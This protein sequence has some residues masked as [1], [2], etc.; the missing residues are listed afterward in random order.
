M[1]SQTG[2]RA[3]SWLCTYNNPEISFEALYQQRQDKIKYMV[4]QL[5]KGQNN[6]PHFQFF[7]QLASPARL[8]F[9]KNWDKNIHAESAKRP[10]KAI[11]YCQKAE[12]RVDG[13][14][15]FGTYL[16]SGRK[17]LSNTVQLLANKS[18]QELA[19]EL[20][21]IRYNAAVKATAHFKIYQKV[22]TAPRNSQTTKGVWL[23]G[24][25][26]VG[27]SWAA[28]KKWPDLY[29][30]AQNKWWDGYTGQDIALIEDFD[31]QG[32]CLSHYIKIWADCYDFVGEVKGNT[33]PIV[34]KYFVITSNYLPGEIWDTDSILLE[35]I[36]RR[37]TII[38]VDEYNRDEC[39]DNL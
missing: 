29:L 9:F 10:E 20:D 5:E 31:K 16:D 30:K 36:E 38:L 1:E 15:S 37:F 17:C 22:R 21:P 7:V 4:G 23:C 12:S 33:I 28:R 11:D 25:P 3:R 27:K 34:L 26:G 13:P 24:K 35:A 32:T 6:T 8:S 2:K 14:W 19:S 18:I 39:L